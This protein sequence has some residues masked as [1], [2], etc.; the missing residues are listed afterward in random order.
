MC[1]AFK[2]EQGLVRREGSKGRTSR[3]SAVSILIVLVADQDL[4]FCLWRGRIARKACFEGE[5]GIDSNSPLLQFY[6]VD[7]FFS[8]G[9]RG[10][11]VEVSPLRRDSLTPL[12]VVLTTTTTKTKKLAPSFWA[13]TESRNRNRNRN[14]NKNRNIPVTMQASLRVRCSTV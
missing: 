1:S 10:V 12:S 2:Q 9:G 7:I 6:A 5:G 4:R 11:E 14:K 3:A 8:G 13:G